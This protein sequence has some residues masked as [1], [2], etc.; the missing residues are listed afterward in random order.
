MRP[1]DS[2]TPPL[3]IPIENLAELNRPTPL[4]GLLSSIECAPFSIAPERAEELARIVEKQELMI[5]LDLFGT[6]FD[7]KV[8]Y[9]RIVVPLRALEHLWAR[10]YAYSILHDT[11][12]PTEPEQRIL[13]TDHPDFNRA[14]RLLQWAQDGEQCE[15]LDEWPDSLPQPDQTVNERVSTANEIFLGMVAFVL[16]HEIGHVVRQLTGDE[17]AIN[18]EDESIAAEFGADQ[19]AICW[20]LG[21]WCNFNTNPLI[22]VKRSTS[23][24]Y[25][26]ASVDAIEVLFASERRGTY[27][28][29]VERQLRFLDQ[30]VPATSSHVLPL[31]ENA[32]RAP[33]VV[34][35]YHLHTLALDEL[36]GQCWDHP[37]NYVVAVRD[38]IARQTK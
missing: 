30:W 10:A 29:I 36:Q 3:K 33:L 9:N 26:L 7:I 28:D 5:R 6:G 38:L 11:F 19:W 23:I 27:P 32:W 13:F 21:A 12:Q 22:F 25:G 15:G 4:N 18:T 14:N 31:E 37:R 34:L 2:S 24:S 20:I 8:V 16:L 1:P 17:P 35:A